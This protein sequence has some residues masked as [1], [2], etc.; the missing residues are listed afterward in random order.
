[1]NLVPVLRHFGNTIVNY[2]D[3]P[4][5]IVDFAVSGHSPARL[6]WKDMQHD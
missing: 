3:N 5:G 4:G 2:F 1:M 6:T